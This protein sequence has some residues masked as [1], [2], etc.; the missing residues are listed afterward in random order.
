MNHSEQGNSRFDQ[1]LTSLKEFLKQLYVTGGIPLVIVAI[2][3]A[4][5][6]VAY[7]EPQRSVV[8]VLLIVIGAI[9]WGASLYVTLLRWRTQAQMLAEQD[10]LI[11]QAV[12]DIARSEKWDIVEKKTG[13]LAQALEQMRAQHL[14]LPATRKADGQQEDKGA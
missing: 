4:N 13:A 11:V 9:S 6:F 14:V 3:A 8:S 12:C 2:G 10:A 1:R 7:A 5:M